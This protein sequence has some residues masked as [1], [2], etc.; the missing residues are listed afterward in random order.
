M[1]ID[2][3]VENREVV[4]RVKEELDQLKYEAKELSISTLIQ[5]KT[6]LFQFVLS[7]KE[8]S[9]TNIREHGMTEILMR[10]ALRFFGFDP[11]DKEEDREEE[12]KKSSW[13]SVLTSKKSPSTNNVVRKSRSIHQ[14]R[15]KKKSTAFYFRRSLKVV[16]FPFYLLFLVLA[17]LFESENEVSRR[18]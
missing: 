10:R 8:Y 1:N 5:L 7:Y 16:L 3:S 14:K 18:K 4:E 15:T 11:G 13:R 2:I 9:L 12:K 17:M 6:I